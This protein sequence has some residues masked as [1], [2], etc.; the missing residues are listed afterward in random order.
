LTN[1]DVVECSK[2]RQNFEEFTGRCVNVALDLTDPA[3]PVPFPLVNVA[4]DWGNAVTSE[5]LCAE[6]C[7]KQRGCNAYEWNGTKCLTYTEPYST[8]RTSAMHGDGETGF[9]CHALRQQYN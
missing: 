3:S 7:Y 5:L 4:K 1:D 2:R 8:T 9:R 6:E